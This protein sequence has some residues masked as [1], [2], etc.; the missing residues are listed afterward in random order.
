MFF[1][2][3]MTFEIKMILC[4]IIFFSRK[5]RV[6]NRDYEITPSPLFS[7]MISEALDL[8]LQRFL[9]KEVLKTRV[10]LC[11][12]QILILLGKKKLK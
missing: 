9:I 7:K 11:N 5:L 2:D 3:S 10:F 6:N 4:F 8:C 1:S 12:N